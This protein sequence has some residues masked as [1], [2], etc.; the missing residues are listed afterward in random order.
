MVIVQNKKNYA[1]VKCVPDFLF[2]L[3]K[4]DVS[5]CKFSFKKIFKTEICSGLLDFESPPEM[6][7]F[8]F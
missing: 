3:T 5:D 1:N 8:T 4:I 7:I 2:L 6:E